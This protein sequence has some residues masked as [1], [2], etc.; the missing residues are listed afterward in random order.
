[1]VDPLRTEYTPPPPPPPPP[2]RPGEKQH[3]VQE[4][5]NLQQIAESHYT[6][7]QAILDVNPQVRDPDRL[8]TGEVLNIPDAT[9]A[10]AVSRTVDALLGADA[11]AEQRN[12]ANVRVQEAVD[13]AGGIGDAGITR[14]A[15][16]AQAQALLERAGLPVV[17]KDVVQSVDMVIGPDASFDQRIAGYKAVGEYVEQV[18]GVSDQGIT[19]EALPA[20]ASQL[21][22]EAGTDVRLREEVITATNGLLADDASPRDRAAAYATVQRYVDQVGG[23]GDAGIVAEA[24]PGKAAQLVAAADNPALRFDPRVMRAVDDVAGSAVTDR[25][26]LSACQALQQHVDSVGGISDQGITEAYL[27]ARAAELMR[28]RGIDVQL[29]AP[30]NASV[31]EVVRIMEAGATPAEQLKVLDQ[32]YRD[33]DPATRDALLADPQVQ[34]AIR[35]AAFDAAG[36]LTRPPSGAEGQAVPFLEAA[37][38]LDT[39]TRDLDPALVG[40]V[41]QNT[42]GLY[43]SY[44]RN[45]SGG[46]TGI[47]GTATFLSVLDR[48]AGTP[49]GEAAYQAIAD[50]GIGLDR[51]GVDQHLFQGGSPAFLLEAG[52]DRD[53][54]VQG[55]QTFANSTLQDKV[56]AYIE[57]TEELNWLV[58]N[59]GGSMTPEQLQTA[60]DDYIADKGPGW[61]DKLEGMQEDI[62]QQ[63]IKLQGQIDALQQAGGN[64]DTIKA[65]LDDPENRLALS[66]ALG[67]H[68]EIATDARLKD[69]A[70]Y[71]KVSEGGRKLL[72]EVANSY[73]KANVLPDVQGANPAD[74]ASMQRAE[75]ALA[76]LNN[77]ALATAYGVDKAK[78]QQAVEELKGTLPRGA[79]TP[80]AAN[81]R[82]SN[83]N[84]TLDGV[85]GFE[86]STGVG[87]LFRALGVAT[88]TFS[89]LNSSNRAFNEPGAY[90]NWLKAG[91]DTFGLAQKTADFL[92]ARGADG[93]A[94][95]ALGGALAGKIATGLTA[96]ADF[97]LG[98][99]AASEGDYAT[100]ALWG[101]SAVGGGLSLAAATGAG[102]AGA[103]AGPVGIALVALAAVGIG[104]VAKV[105]ESNKHD[106]E[107][108]AAFLRHAGFDQDAASALVDQSGDGHSPVPLLER[109]AELKGYDLSDPAQR[110]TFVDW[111]NDMPLER[112]EHLRDW[113]HHT[114]D[115]FGGDISKFGSDTTV[116]IPTTWTRT[117]P[118]AEVWT[119]GPYTVGEFDA[120]VQEYGGTPLPHA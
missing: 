40:A 30:A 6:T 81:T 59:H 109:Y 115:D 66:T 18:G 12:E 36:P 90:A 65:L 60:I 91:A 117:A 38:N 22:R 98:L 53:T 111:V 107:T 20:R 113:S 7:E 101:V 73:V 68:P 1:M 14:E 32:A 46:M 112:L 9:V 82:L 77:S 64:D 71:A 27:P 108:S 62:A 92:V 58:A 29:D 52:Y 16:P 10:P 21:L 96:V 104:L 102:W 86:K 4:G 25:E 35:S 74:P 28:E 72:G 80:E 51:N 37:Q 5:E 95:K 33:A 110:Q 39:L 56:T 3:T 42:S 48:A 31:D 114:L 106:N 83:F 79:D 78:L 103:W 93:S 26:K 45:D 55:V 100:A 75:A 89:F 69:Y 99:K 88:T 15:L 116:H 97:A 70:L 34:Q 84:K 23:V 94:T 8:S 24:L 2:E 19:A 57:E 43:A 54:I 44:A 49:Q 50:T 85:K 63:G 67:R 120:F 118:P 41:L 87:Q 47:E 11:T 105:N 76:R 17:P 61:Q 13:D 119:H